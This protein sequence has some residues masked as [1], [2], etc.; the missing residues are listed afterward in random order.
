[1]ALRSHWEVAT[2]SDFLIIHPNC[3]FSRLYS[4]SEYELIKE[5]RIHHLNFDELIR[6]EDLNVHPQFFDTKFPLCYRLR[7]KSRG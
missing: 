4:C 3:A 7:G 1:M 2:I 5:G 6:F